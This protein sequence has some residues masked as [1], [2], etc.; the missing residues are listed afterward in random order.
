MQRDVPPLRLS[1]PPPTPSSFLLLRNRPPLGGPRLQPLR[2]QV[3]AAP[4]LARGRKV[5]QDLRQGP[6]P[7]H[8]GAG[9]RRGGRTG[10]VQVPKGPAL[11]ARHRQVLPGVQQ[12]PLRA[13]PVPGEGGP[14]VKRD[15]TL[16]GSWG[17]VAVRRR[18][19]V[20]ERVDLLAKAREVL[21]AL[22]PG[23]VPQGN[24]QSTVQSAVDEKIVFAG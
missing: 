6:L 18:Q 12:G 17:P 2:T 19:E 20:R 21:P 10:A 13:Q 1:P 15:G 9:L 22:H 24:F 4:A 16:D 3:L 11:L 7:A 14:A 5:L 23:A 8:A